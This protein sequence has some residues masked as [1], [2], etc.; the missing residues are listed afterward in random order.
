MSEKT[1]AQKAIENRIVQK[2]CVANKKFQDYSEHTDYTE[3]HYGDCYNDYGDYVDAHG[4]YY[5]CDCRDSKTLPAEKQVLCPVV[6]SNIIQRVFQR[7][8]GRGS[9]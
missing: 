3:S 1:F 2:Q 6:K 7:I 9:R 5:D 8:F 4:D